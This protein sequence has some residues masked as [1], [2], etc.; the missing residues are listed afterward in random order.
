[1]MRRE[2]ILTQLVGKHAR[3][4]RRT[5]NRIL[6]DRDLTED[7]LQESWRRV[8]ASPVRLATPHDWENY[9]QRVLVNTARDHWKARTR[10]SLRSV[11]LE[12]AAQLADPR[13]SAL[14]QVLNNE[15]R[16]R[17][18]QMLREALTIISTLPLSQRQAIFLL[19]QKDPAETLAEI[20]RREGIPVSTLRSRMRAGIRTIRR[21]LRQKGLLT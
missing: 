8:L 6:K 10:R 9:F 16:L 13:E 15:R 5:V 14:V 4:W 7:V 21:L 12:E 1:M 11:L 17:D 2:D 20:S 18:H 3:N 19:I